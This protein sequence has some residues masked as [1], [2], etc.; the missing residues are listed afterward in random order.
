MKQRLRPVGRR[1]D[2]RAR[3]NRASDNRVCVKWP[4]VNRA[5]KLIIGR[6]KEVY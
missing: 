6:V 5:Y 2:N 3:V 1:R 4:C